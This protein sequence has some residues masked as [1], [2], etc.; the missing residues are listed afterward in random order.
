MPFKKLASREPVSDA[1]A[2]IAQQLAPMVSLLVSK[3]DD[4][5]RAFVA[6]VLR[7]APLLEGSFAFTGADL[8][9]A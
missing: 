6:N 7:S 3:E 2:A 9:A 8:G 5:R 4:R 1:D